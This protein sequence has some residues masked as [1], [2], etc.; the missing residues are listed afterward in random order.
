MKFQHGQGDL[1]RGRTVSAGIALVAVVYAFLA[2]TVPLVEAAAPKNKVRFGILL[3]IKDSLCVSGMQYWITAQKAK[4][5][6]QANPDVDWELE[7][8][9]L[10]ADTSFEAWK[11]SSDFLE[12]DPC[13]EGQA[14]CSVLQAGLIGPPET[15][16]TRFVQFVAHTKD[17]PVLSFSA[18]GNDLSKNL[19]G[20]VLDKQDKEFFRVTYTDSL[21]GA[22]LWNAVHHFGFELVSVVYEGTAY[23]RSLIESLESFAASSE[24]DIVTSQGFDVNS[25]SS[26]RDALSEVEERRARIILLLSFG[27]NAAMV[28]DEAH[29]KEM[30]GKGWNWLG[31]D[32]VTM[33]LADIPFSAARWRD[34]STKEKQETSDRIKTVMEGAVGVV[35]EKVE[36][37]NR[38]PRSQ[39]LQ[40]NYS[41]F[42]D[43]P[44]I[45][46]PPS[47][48]TCKPLQ[49]FPF[50]GGIKNADIFVPYV[51]DTVRVAAHSTKQVLRENS[52]DETHR[53]IRKKI[54][55]NLEETKVK[56][57]PTDIPISFDE[58][59]DRR[60]L[61]LRLSNV[62][63]SEVK[64][65]ADWEL[66]SDIESMNDVSWDDSGEWT[67]WKTIV[68]PGGSTGIPSDRVIVDTEETAF[69]MSVVFVGL[70]ISLI[71]GVFIHKFHIHFIPESGV[72][73]LLGI[74]FGLI[75][76]ATAADET[77]R[78]AQFDETL[79]MLVLLPIIIF[80]SGYALDKHPF[81]SQLGTIITCAIVGTLIVTFLTAFG[82]WGVGEAGLSVPLSI[83]ESMTF[84]ALI[85]AVD[86]VAVLATFTILRVDPRLNSLVYGEAVINDAVAIV[87]FR[88]FS[89]FITKEIDSSSVGEAIGSF[90]GVLLGSVVIGALLG[91]LATFIFRFKSM[92]WPGAHPPGLLQT[93][94]PLLLAYLSFAV[95]EA[96]EL[97]GIVC[98]LFCGIMMNHYMK[99]ALSE[100]GEFL[101]MRVFRL[102][103]V[104]AES[105]VFFLIGMNIV[106]YS[107]DFD[108]KFFL[109]TTFFCLATRLFHVFPISFIL[110]LGRK[111]KIP[112]KYQAVM[113]WG[114]A[115]RG[116]VAYGT[117]VLFP[118]QYKDLVVT[119][120]AWVVM[121][122]IFVNGGST[123][124]LLDKLGIPMGVEPEE[125]KDEETRHRL[126]VGMTHQSEKESIFKGLLARLDRGIIRP[127]LHS[128]EVRRK[129][130][131]R[132]NS[133]E[134]DAHDA[135]SNEPLAVNEGNSHPAIEASKETG[136][137]E[138]TTLH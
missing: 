115:L 40:Q 138:F 68:W 37:L 98:S 122:T 46:I 18:T 64:L 16:P 60:K 124:T 130:R 69:I 21:V 90:F 126:R 106:L 108:L 94:I 9:P 89:E 36:E 8:L 70:V 19:G 12:L 116:A 55:R 29:K 33:N 11:S 109:W 63:E 110:N 53:E 25:P 50:V 133:P 99:K 48:L 134:G 52:W 44:L 117:A 14:N 38:F 87:L 7:L 51:Y 62:Q 4:E 65:V 96:L 56:F 97:S 95:A 93:A 131:Y 72:V 2:M 1:R 77:A 31:T 112:M 42:T 137:D 100:E 30:Y 26:V 67:N 102:L 59:H 39:Y 32:W 6:F 76:R 105:G 15:E 78:S 43:E 5:D 79:F 49:R 13:D 54:I 86:P 23:G 91:M 66:A 127:C 83:E 114:G 28:L 128:R 111:E 73:I 74:A 135:D 120:T 132:A 58:N 119:T 57:S 41:A 121:F 136:N 123:T 80:E 82:L 125:E 45:G 88:T 81:F 107:G 47:N 10:T 24:I 71:I 103:A 22:A 3:P 84:S 113:Y 20:S 27:S 85:S 17:Y 92:L 61:H 129:H 34:S 75:I 101:T 35:P 118:S 104:L